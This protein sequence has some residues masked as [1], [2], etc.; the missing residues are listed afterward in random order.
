M[1]PAFHGII[2]MPSGNLRSASAVYAKL[3][4]HYEFAHALAFNLELDLRGSIDAE[5][6]SHFF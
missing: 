2:F 3:T 4:G 5:R 6:P 1:F